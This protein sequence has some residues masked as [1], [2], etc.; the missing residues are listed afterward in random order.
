MEFLSSS[1]TPWCGG[2]HESDVG[3]VIF[4]NSGELFRRHCSSLAEGTVE[5][6]NRGF[7]FARSCLCPVAGRALAPSPAT[8][9]CTTRPGLR[10]AGT[11]VGRRPEAAP[12]PWREEE[13]EAPLF[14]LAPDL[15]CFLFLNSCVLS[16]FQ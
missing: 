1:S 6:R 16:I 12:W 13:D 11:P 14:N 5:N 15:S 7:L 8:A 3:S 2:L 9:A 10:R 4:P